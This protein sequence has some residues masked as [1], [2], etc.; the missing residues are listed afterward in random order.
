MASGFAD[1]SEACDALL[2]SCRWL[3]IQSAWYG[4]TPFMRLLKAMRTREKINSETIRLSL[5]CE[6]RFWIVPTRNRCSTE[7]SMYVLRGSA[8]Y[9]CRAV[10]GPLAIN[11]GCEIVDHYP[12]D[13]VVPF[14]FPLCFY[15]PNV[16]RCKKN[17]A[18]AR[19]ILCL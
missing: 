11:Q 16:R 7:Q 19:K 9:H 6:H 4:S 2:A 3:D 13:R 15:L 18:G 14:F 10:S 5:M 8:A 12:P 1:P 17:A